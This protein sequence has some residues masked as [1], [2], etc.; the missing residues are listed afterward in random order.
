MA[1]FNSYVSL[2][3]GILGIPYF[4]KPRE[5]WLLATAMGGSEL[6]GHFMGQHDSQITWTQGTHPKNRHKSRAETS[7]ALRKIFKVVPLHKKKD[8][9][10][11]I[12]IDISAMNHSYWT[13]TNLANSYP[14]VN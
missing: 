6:T 7:G 4:K 13:C 9:N 3:E 11:I 10:P 14:L 1:V 5:K 2:P 8:Y 12:T